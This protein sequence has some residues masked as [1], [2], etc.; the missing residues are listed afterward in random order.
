M[1]HVLCDRLHTTK[2]F[3]MFKYVN[4]RMHSIVPFILGIP[5]CIGIGHLTSL[6]HVIFQ[7]LAFTLHGI[8]YK[9]MFSVHITTPPQ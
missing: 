2:C 8:T 3:K 5:V 6:S 1:Y 7:I 9:Y 4:T